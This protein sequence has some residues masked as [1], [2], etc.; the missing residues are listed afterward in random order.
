MAGIAPALF[1]L[2][3]AACVAACVAEVAHAAQREPAPAITGMDDPARWTPAYWIERAPDAGQVLASPGLI[4]ARN[5]RLLREDPSLH[6]LA[7]IGPVLERARVVD[8]IESIS[9]RPTAPRHDA[10]GA[11]VPAT[12]FDA[13]LDALALDAVPARQP[14][15]YGLVVRRAALRT[16]P[17]GLRV[18]S[19]PGDTDI[20]R[21]QESALFPG[22]PVVIAHASRD[23]Q[24]LFV[25]S[26]RYAAW[27]EAG[28][29]AE[30]DADTVLGFANR[31]PFRLVTGATAHTV[32]APDAPAVSALQLDM[33]TRLPVAD[34]SPTHA[35]NRQHPG[36]GHVV[37]VPVRDAAGRL[38]LQP[39][40]LPRSADTADAPLPL[41]RSNTI[42]QAFKFLGERYG[43]GHDYNARDCSGFVSEVYASMGVL[44]PRNTGDQARSPVLDIQ[45]LDDAGARAA[46][47]STLQV[48]DLV[49]VPG[50]VMLVIGHANSEP[51]VIHDIH[52]GGQRD[53]DGGVARLRLN[54]VVVTTLRSLVFEDGTPYVDRAN[55][56]VRPY[57][58][59]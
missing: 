17:T 52:G 26:P 20:D 58:I 14:T 46:A 1:A 23:G 18:F 2:G 9:R 27:I 16:F 37:E 19:T 48:G 53:A 12:T 5:T 51:Y 4:E 33:G 39:A 25:V 34:T 40:L 44:L 43:W 8:W 36:S 24:W 56:I 42:A 21:F 47:L 59:R 32:L 10:S 45:P 3:L 57:A 55:A 31:T 41:T 22:T 29:V 28:G 54:G 15:R 13:L 30:G 38:A 35:V 49:Y 11:P 7:A 6:D 50:H